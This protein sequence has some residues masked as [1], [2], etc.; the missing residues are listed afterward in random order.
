VISSD[1]PRRQNPWFMIHSYSLIFSC[2]TTI[3]LQ[4]NFVVMRFITHHSPNNALFVQPSIAVVFSL[5]HDEPQKGSVDTRC[6]G[7]LR[8]PFSILDWENLNQGAGP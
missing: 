4:Y 8:A 6:T 1:E 3:S 2:I 5:N 7:V